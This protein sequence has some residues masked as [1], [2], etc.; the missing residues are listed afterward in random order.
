MYSGT[1]SNNPLMT[2]LNGPFAEPGPLPQEGLVGDL[3]HRLV[4]P[5][6]GLVQQPCLSEGGQQ[7]LG[8]GRRGH[9]LQRCPPPGCHPALLGR[10]YLE[11][12]PEHGSERRPGILIQR[13]AGVLGAPADGA[14]HPAE[15]LVGRVRE[16]AFGGT[17]VVKLLQ[18]KG[19]QR[20]GAGLGARV[21]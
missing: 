18:G 8:F 2:K 11:Q 19:H 20:Q 21:V 14:P 1:V 5:A 13:L 16:L 4:V 15:L 6:L 10:V 7:S 3:H 9:P 12:L 17:P